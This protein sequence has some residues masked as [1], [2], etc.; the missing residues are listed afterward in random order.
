MSPIAA[1][2]QGVRRRISEALQGDSR[3]VRLVAVSKTR[4]PDMISEAL[5]A[6]CRDFGENYVQEAIPKIAAIGQAGACWHFIGPLQSNKARDVAQAF[7]WYQGLDRVK[8]AEALSKARP[9]GREP[10]QVCIQVNISGEATKS[11]VEANEVV[12]LA[13]A[14][15][16][17][18]G[19]KLRGLMGIAAPSEDTARQRREFATL[20]VLYEGLRDAGYSLDTLSMG[21]TDDLEAAIAEGSTMVRIGTAIFGS[22]E[23]AA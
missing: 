6:G 13:E 2:L 19:L 18:P 21:M 16:A 9:A 1:N 22:R 15:A 11:G 14:V 3:E 5:A 12:P 7:D 8:I 23:R 10:L 4:S 20:R 17:L